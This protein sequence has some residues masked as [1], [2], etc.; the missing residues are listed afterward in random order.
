MLREGYNHVGVQGHILAM[1]FNRDGIPV[2]RKIHDRNV[3]RNKR[4]ERRLLVFL[5]FD[6]NKPVP[7]AHTDLKQ[8]G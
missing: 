6:C 2:L 8:M 7:C 4:D 5:A 1:V 3:G